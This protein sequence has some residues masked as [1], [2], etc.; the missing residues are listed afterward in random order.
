MVYKS[1]ITQ[2]SDMSNRK[3]RLDPLSVSF[4]HDVQALD[5]KIIHLESNSRILNQNN[6][7]G[8]QETG[9]ING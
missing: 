5:G 6:A 8:C 2:Q 1:P 4:K 9:S 3:M 7:V